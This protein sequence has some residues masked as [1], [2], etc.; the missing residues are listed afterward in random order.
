MPSTF[1]PHCGATVSPELDS[2]CTNCR[3]SLDEPPEGPPPIA[4]PES[5]IRPWWVTVTYILIAFHIVGLV[6]WLLAV[7]TQ[8]R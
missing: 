7:F 4:L 5:E 3:H 1:C 8:R 2:F 6:L